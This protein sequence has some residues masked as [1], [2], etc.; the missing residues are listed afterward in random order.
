LRFGY[1]Q[2]EGENSTFDTI[3]R[4]HPYWRI[5]DWTLCKADTQFALLERSTN[6]FLFFGQ[7]SLIVNDYLTVKIGKFL[8]PFGYFQEMIH[9]APTTALGIAVS[10]GIPIGPT[11]LVYAL[12]TSNGPRLVSDPLTPLDQ[13]SLRYDNYPD[14]NNNK[15]IGG[16]IGFMPMIPAEIGFSILRAPK[17]GDSDSIYKNIGATIRGLDLNYVGVVESIKS[18]LDFKFETVESKVDAADYG[19][20]TYDNVRR[21]A[22][23]QFAYRPLLVK[24]PWL[25]KLEL[26]I[27]ND[28]V[29]MPKMSPLNNVYRQAYG[30]NY[31]VHDTMG[32]KAA[33]EIARTELNA[34]VPAAARLHGIPGANDSYIKYPEAKTRHNFL[35]QIAIGF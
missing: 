2:R 1:I 10:G 27:R 28:Y 23:W 6:V 11:R 9:V 22:Y 19:A 31:W 16:R 34:S 32:I 18:K 21:G 3:V 30:I 14:N 15:D 33:Y 8:S 7:C 20:G 26:L 29:I 25:S 17:V 35:F 13:G 5:D 12:Y 24:T 4:F